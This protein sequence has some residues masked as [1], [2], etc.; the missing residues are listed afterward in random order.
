VGRLSFKPEVNVIEK[1]SDKLEGVPAWQLGLG[2]VAFFGV[3]YLALSYFNVRADSFP[4]MGLEKFLTPLGITVMTAG[5]VVVGVI[6]GLVRE[7]FS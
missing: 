5:A 3:L 1:L 6:G 7:R 2:L 4:L